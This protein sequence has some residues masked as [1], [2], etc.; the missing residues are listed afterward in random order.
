MTKGEL[1]ELAH[2]LEEIKNKGSVLFRYL[3]IKNIAALKEIKDILLNIANEHKKILADFEVDRNELISK[4]GEPKEGRYV[5]D[6][7]NEE[8]LKLFNEGLKE[9]TSKHKESLDLFQNNFTEYKELLKEELETSPELIRI[10]AEYLPE[11]ITSP[12]LEFL[13][14]F[15]LIE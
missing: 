7:N 15:N 13:N 11:D 12:Q 4:I 5:I 10:P 2:L 8:V 9:L 6:I 14:S 1:L 3:V